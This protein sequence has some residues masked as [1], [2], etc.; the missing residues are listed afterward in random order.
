[1]TAT[2]TEETVQDD[3]RPVGEVPPSGLRALLG[4]GWETGW[5]SGSGPGGRPDRPTISEPV[6]AHRRRPARRRPR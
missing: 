6:G 5:D 3:D 2:R 1:M 4:N